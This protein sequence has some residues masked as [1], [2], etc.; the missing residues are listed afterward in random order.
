VHF[1]KEG[2]R[3]A[4][5]YFFGEGPERIGCEFCGACITGCRKDAK[6]SLD[7]NYLY[8][9]QK[10][11]ASIIPEQKVIAVT[12]QSDDGSK[13]YIVTSVRTT[14]ILPQK[15]TYRAK[16]V[17]LAGG[18]LGTLSLL[19]TM[20]EQGHLP[21]L[22]DR[23]G[24]VVRTNSEAIVAVKSNARDVDYSKGVA[25]TSSVY[26]DEHTHMEPVRYAR[27]ND[28][29]GLLMVLLTDGDGK[30]PRILKYLGNILRHPI[31]F[32]RLLNPIGFALHSIMVLVMQTHD[33][34]LN[35]FRKRRLL[36]P[37]IKTLN[38][39]QA[40]DKK[41]P[42]HIPIANEFCR[43][44]AKRI[45]GT[46]G[47]IITEVCLNAPVTAH[48]MGGC[49][50]GENSKDGVIDEQNR[51][52][53]YRN[54]LVVDGAMIPANI[55]ANPALTITA[56]SERAMSFIPVKEGQPMRYLK[57]ERE[58]GVTERLFQEPF[59]NQSTE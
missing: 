50:P 43:R 2:E 39:E 58:W 34:Y 45:N 56:M 47:N 18:V 28:L 54:M 7:K 20:K 30:T 35:V 55:G 6:N 51:V 3:T 52:N 49:S 48:I 15:T 38:S 33:N 17:V 23:L 19:M 16:G 12:P 14:G 44:L 22:S 41:N 46:P 26:P 4:D 10:F 21:R 36:W 25:I 9:A 57:A 24:K 8:F 5:P 29:M 31:G 37:F 59:Q 13:G 40:S 27:G 11:G 1:G 53:G 42:V 32:L